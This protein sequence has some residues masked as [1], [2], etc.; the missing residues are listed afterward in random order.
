[1]QSWQQW[2]LHTQC[3]VSENRLCVGQEKMEDKSNEITAIPKVL[4]SSDITDQAVSIDAIG[5]QTAIV[6]QI[7]DRNGHYFLSVKA[8]RESLLD[9]IEC[10]FKVNQGHDISEDVEKDHGRIETGRCSIL[11]AKEFVSDEILSAWRNLE[12]LI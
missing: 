7:I 3:R 8:N 1:M 12:T 5:T 9:D 10:T 2:V 6:N 11:S 4:E